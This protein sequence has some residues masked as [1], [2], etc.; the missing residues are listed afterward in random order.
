LQLLRQLLD[1]VLRPIQKILPSM[2]GLDFSPM[3]L[4]MLIHIL[5]AYLL[6]VLARGM[7]VV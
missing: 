6:P 2:G 1:P 4:L 3:I 7:G 5:K